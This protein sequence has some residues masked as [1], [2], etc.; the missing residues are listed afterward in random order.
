VEDFNA[1]FQGSTEKEVPVPQH[2]GQFLL[3]I[4]EYVYTYR[5]PLQAILGDALHEA[6]VMT[7]E[8]DQQVYIAPRNSIAAGHGTKEKDTEHL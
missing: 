3:R 1:F 5:Y 4:G 2:L 7:C 6:L 8:N